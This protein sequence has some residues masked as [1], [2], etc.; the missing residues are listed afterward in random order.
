MKH[1]FTKHLIAFAL[2]SSVSIVSMVSMAH[3]SDYQCGLMVSDTPKALMPAA[4]K[5]EGNHALT[6]EQKQKIQRI[7]IAT[8]PKVHELVDQI[9]KLDRA[10]LNAVVKEGKSLADVTSQLDELQQLRRKATEM[11]LNALHQLS[12]TV[13]KE[14]YER[15]LTLSGWKTQ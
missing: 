8:G 10:I 4:M 13:S 12:Q 9:E 14:Q 5:L 6:D 15:I 2:V 3:E 1:E 7:G 11:K